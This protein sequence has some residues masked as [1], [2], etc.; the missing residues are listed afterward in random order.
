MNKKNSTEEY[1]DLLAEAEKLKDDIIHQIS[2]NLNFE[3]FILIDVPVLLEKFITH[4][5]QL[6]WR[7]RK[8]EE[9]IKSFSIASIE[10]AISELSEMMEKNLDGQIKLKCK[11]SLEIY[12]NHKKTLN[13]YI[14]QKEKIKEKLDNTVFSLLKIKKDLVKL[15]NM[16]SNRMRLEFYSNF[17]NRFGINELLEE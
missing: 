8:L 3:D 7:Y 16:D 5:A 1:I 15:E 4:T 17:K 11:S 9:I 2:T 14:V 10:N 12:E 13:G 6:L